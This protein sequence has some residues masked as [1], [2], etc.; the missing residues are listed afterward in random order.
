[1]SFF[2]PATFVR[3]RLVDIQAA[4]ERLD[5][6]LPRGSEGEFRRLVRRMIALAADTRGQL[7]RLPSDPVL[8]TGS[9]STDALLLVLNNLWAVYGPA[10]TGE[11][12]PPVP[13]G[14]AG[15]V[16][17]S[18]PASRTGLDRAGRPLGGG[19]RSGR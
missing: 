12:E 9:I 13:V 4:A 6:M 5:A 14:E 11:V 17:Q 18:P 8:Y 19:Y 15:E 2:L 3:E 16:E 10:A 7:D 1:L